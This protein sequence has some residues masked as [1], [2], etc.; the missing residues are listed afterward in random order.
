MNAQQEAVALFKFLE[1]R[2]F[3]PSV[4][5]IGRI[6]RDPS[7]KLKC[8]ES[9]LRKWLKNFVASA[10]QQRR[11]STQETSTNDAPR[12]NADASPTQLRAHNKVSLVSGLTEKE[13]ER[14]TREAE[15]R[16]ETPAKK[17]ERE[18]VR[19]FVRTGKEREAI[20][21]HLVLDPELYANKEFERFGDLA[22]NLL[23]AHGE[24]KCKA[25]SHR[26]F[27]A[28]L[29][30]KIY[31]VS[32]KML[33]E[34]WS[35]YAQPIA[36][37]NKPAARNDSRAPQQLGRPSTMEEYKIKLAEM[38][39]REKEQSEQAYATMLA[40]R[41]YDRKMAERAAAEKAAVLG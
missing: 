38:K 35:W 4:R 27:D 21:A 11:T 15:E 31:S 30:G 17:P 39:Q 33:S 12:R 18:F 10:T 41:E 26:L 20:E 22:R 7:I 28:K 6:L 3:E 24:D 25:A 16:Q 29:N 34:N 23:S 40:R 37:Q 5:C 36:P 8:T 32:L 13:R 9:E 1:G 19:W 2:G 14:E